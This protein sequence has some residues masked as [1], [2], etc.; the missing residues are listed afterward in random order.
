[1]NKDLYNAYVSILEKE[2]VVA[3]GCTE[4]IAIAFACAKVRDVLG[5]VPTHVDI[6]CSGNIIKNVKGVT[7]PHSNGRKG[8]E[9]A[10]I[11]GLLAGHSERGLAVLEGVC[12]NDLAVC[13]ELLA[14]QICNVEIVEN[15]PN[16][17]IRVVATAVTD[18]VELIIKDTH[19]NIVFIKKNGEVLFNELG[20]DITSSTKQDLKSLLN[21]AQILEFA[22]TV[23][24]EL[25][26]PVLSQQIECNLKI[27]EEG[28]TNSYGA[29]VGQ[30]I[31]DHQCSTVYNK[32]RAYAA[33][34]SDARMSG[35]PLPVVINSGSG[36]QGIT[37]SLPVIIYAK[38]HKISEELLYR[39]L[40]VSNLIALHQKRYIGSLSAYC[41]AVSA[42]CGSACGI[43]FLEGMDY[44][45]ISAVITN[46]IATIGGMVC[47]GAKPS[48]ASKIAVALESAFLGLEMAK[49][50]RYFKPGEGLVKEDI[51]KTIACVGT[52]GRVGMYGTDVQILNL[53][54]DKVEL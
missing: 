21:V 15:V 9:V 33:A 52:M 1:M 24:L 10:A 16:L 4:P 42:A 27:A 54:L 2:L 25:V 46:T 47:D 26:K 51:E 11:L 36:N 20:H 7:V 18:T 41:G 28:L 8:I 48:C 29:M 38:E 5:S 14:N 31:R 23:D 17:Y 32:A 35:C 19:S 53:M 30:T 43:A 37:V 13:E 49:N 44:E 45:G 40:V 22:K 34:G 12:E 50:E 3:L 39:A 6:H